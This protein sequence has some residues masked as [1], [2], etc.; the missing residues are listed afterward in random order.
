MFFFRGRSSEN[1]RRIKS[2]QDKFVNS[3]VGYLIV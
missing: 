3:H 2:V 1:A